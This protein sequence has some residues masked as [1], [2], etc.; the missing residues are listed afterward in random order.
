[1]LHVQTVEAAMSPKL[2]AECNYR[3]PKLGILVSVCC[4]FLC[5]TSD[6]VNYTK[7]KQRECQ[8]GNVH[9]R[10]CRTT[11]CL[12]LKC[13]RR[14]QSNH[15]SRSPW[16]MPSLSTVDSL[17]LSFSGSLPFA[18]K[19]RKWTPISMQQQYTLNWLSQNWF[20]NKWQQIL[21]GTNLSGAQRKSFTDPGELGKKRGL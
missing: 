21:S 4:F 8:A 6:D 15:P 9:A 12:T 18:Q 1:M 14:G 5:G 19:D 10:S 11:G 3:P 20:H 13:Q 2:G 16:H 7:K 17:V